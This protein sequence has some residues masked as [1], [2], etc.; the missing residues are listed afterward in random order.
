MKVSAQTDPFSHKH[1]SFRRGAGSQV[2]ANPAAL[3]FCWHLRVG[4][5]RGIEPAKMKTYADFFYSTYLDPHLCAQEQLIIACRGLQPAVTRKMMASHRKLRRLFG[6][7]NDLLRTMGRIEDALEHHVRL[8]QRI[9][10][11]ELYSQYLHNGDDT[12][13]LGRQF[14]DPLLALKLSGWKDRYWSLE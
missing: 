8:E 5:V 11:R 9:L 7:S 3:Q 14:Y 2:P 10:F 6:N 1:T 13:R 12:S 4:M